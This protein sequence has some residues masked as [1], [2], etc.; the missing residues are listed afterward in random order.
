[1]GTVI[2]DVENKLVKKDIESSSNQL[3]VL[4][5]GSC[6]AQRNL[7]CLTFEQNLSIRK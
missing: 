3:L 7:S 4:K 6:L 5:T 2:E 1:M